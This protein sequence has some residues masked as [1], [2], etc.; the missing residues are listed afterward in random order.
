MIMMMYPW[1]YPSRYVLSLDVSV[2]LV[3]LTVLSVLVD[4]SSI[5]DGSMGDSLTT[6]WKYD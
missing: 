6:G 4:D 2:V 5:T 1:S 3:Q